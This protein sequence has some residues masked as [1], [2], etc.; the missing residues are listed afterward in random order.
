MYPLSSQKKFWTFSSMDQLN[1]LRQKQ[2][3][4]FIETHGQEIDEEQRL[5]YFLDASEERLLIKQYEIYLND[6][7]RRFEPMMPKCVVGTA[8]HYFKRFYLHNSTMDYHPKEILATV[9]YLACKV[10]EFNVSIGQFVSNIKGDRNKAMDIIL[11]NELLLMQHL[12]Y[13]LT[14]HNPYRPIEGFLIDIKTRS[15]MANPERLRPHIDSFIEKTFFT[16]ACL[17]YA[18]SQIAL[19]AIL[20]A[21]GREQENLDSYVTDNLLNG[22]RE[23]LPALI[24]A[25]R[26]IRLLVKQYEIPP[27]DRVKAIEKKLE[28]CRNQENNPDSEVYKERMR[29]MYC[30]DDLDVVEDTSYHIADSSAD[31][32]VLN[33]SQ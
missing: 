15:N 9:V 13:Y 6:F 32:S 30:D 20:H 27:R 24:E 18:P 14:V 4:K 28:K 25:I 3:Q 26:K 33:M 21:A 10:E 31:M 16:D 8:F 22:A 17:L 5:E 19:A 29:K 12:N 1:E 2:N 7:C 23:K 11:S